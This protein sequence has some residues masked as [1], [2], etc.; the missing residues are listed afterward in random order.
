[1]DRSSVA[2]KVFAG[3]VLAIAV[4][5]LWCLYPLPSTEAQATVA[6]IMARGM[7]IS[8]SQRDSLISSI[9]STLLLNRSFDAVLLVAASATSAALLRRRSTLAAIA[10]LVYSGSALFYAVASMNMA[11]WGLESPLAY[12]SRVSLLMANSDFAGNVG[13]AFR[14]VSVTF[15]CISVPVALWYLVRLRVVGRI[16]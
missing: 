7:D 4:G 14:V 15:A 6:R 5:H 8:A 2:P 16:S 11:A 12:V 9:Y 10:T 3:L 13:F 1:M